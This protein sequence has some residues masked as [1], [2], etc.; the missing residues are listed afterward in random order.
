MNTRRR[1][2]SDPQFVPVEPS[3]HD[4]VAGGEKIACDRRVPRKNPVGYA[5][6]DDDIRATFPET[7]FCVSM[8]TRDGVLDLDRMRKKTTGK[9]LGT[10]V[11]SRATLCAM[12]A[13]VRS[14]AP[15][16]LIPVFGQI[17]RV[18]KFKNSALAK[19]CAP[20]T[21]DPHPF[22]C[23]PV[24]V[25]T[26]GDG[27]GDQGDI[28]LQGIVAS[29]KVVNRA[30]GDPRRRTLG[31]H[32]AFEETMCVV[33]VTHVYDPPVSYA[34][35]GPHSTKKRGDVYEIHPD[36][37]PG[38]NAHDSVFLWNEFM[39]ARSDERGCGVSSFGFTDTKQ[40]GRDVVR[41]MFPWS[42]RHAASVLEEFRRH[43]D[44]RRFLLETPMTLMGK[45]A[46]ARKEC[47]SGI[48]VRR[49]LLAELLLKNTPLEPLL[50]GEPPVFDFEE[51]RVT[52]SDD[53]SLW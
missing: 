2:P 22:A 49:F 10:I 30:V 3:E 36:K 19:K 15:G 45:R 44:L 52:D 25:A 35:L 53:G 20:V 11:V 23:T 1:D 41:Y 18:E 29:N 38:R 47:P 46:P 5:T 48:D 37:P 16:V 31:R 39:R 27:H 4:P 9:S 51:P 17:R 7:A 24:V 40:S 6:L 13:T 14:L 33:L 32:P 28:V 12:V 26:T 42:I 21:D 50:R 8:P 34:S 43:D